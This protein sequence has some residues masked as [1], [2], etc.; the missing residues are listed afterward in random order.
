MYFYTKNAVLT[1][2]P[3]TLYSLSLMNAP[4][5]TNVDVRSASYDRWRAMCH[6]EKEIG[7]GSRSM[8]AMFTNISERASYKSEM[9]MLNNFYHYARLLQMSKIM[10]LYINLYMPLFKFSNLL[11][12]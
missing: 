10:L 8:G 1:N 7:D 12:L 5:E 4:S 11:S 3:C 9:K 2:K 6:L